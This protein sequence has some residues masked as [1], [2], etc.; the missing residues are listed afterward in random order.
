MA[1]GEA[2]RRGE[3]LTGR[4]RGLLCAAR[5]FGLGVDRADVRFTAHLGLPA[6]LEEYYQQAGRAGRDGAPSACWL[7]LQ[8]QSARRARRWACL[9]VERLRAELSALSPEERDDVSRAYEF[10]LAAF[11][12]EAAERRDAELALWAAGDPASP[13]DV[14]LETAE[15]DQA[16]R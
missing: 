6:S 16:R 1:R 15:P 13:G 2:P 11:P 3:F 9:P 4:R 7:I 8:V 12:G 10:H 5:A 14:Q